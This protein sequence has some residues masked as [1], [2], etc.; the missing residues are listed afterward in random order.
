M[1]SDRDRTPYTEAVLHEV[2]R[3]GN[4]TAIAFHSAAR[5]CQLGG[6]HVPKGTQVGGIR[7]CFPA[8]LKPFALIFVL[9]CRAF[10]G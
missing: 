2:Q 3:R 6:H 10:N 8:L 1:A 9:F 7:G 4:I 5:D